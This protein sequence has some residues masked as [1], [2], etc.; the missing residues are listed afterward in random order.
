MKKFSTIIIILLMVLAL[1]ACEKKGN[2]SDQGTEVSIYYI[3]SKTSALVSE[4]YKMISTDRDEQIEELLYMLKLNPE[5][6]L[7]K[8]AFT[9]IV[10]VKEFTFNEDSSLTINFES[11]YHELSGINEVLC[12]AAVVKTIT[13]IPDVEFIQFAVNGQPLMDSNS[14]LVGIMTK[15]DFIDNTGTET[16][17]KLY[18]TNSKGNALVEYVTDITYTG[19]GSLEELV[20]KELMK[21][22]SQIGMYPTIP[23]GTEL[24]EVEMKEG[25]CYVDF[26]DK[27]KEKIPNLKDEIVIYSI[28]NTLIELPYISKVQFLING[29]V[30]PTFG[31]GI[32]FD[33]FFERNLSLI[34]ES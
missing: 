26:S 11:N 9:D 17:I 33:G 28:V 2:T 29:E 32:P 19:I 13:Q 15:E 34:D 5:N 12:R 18:F 14:N 7:Y 27:F 20:L 6:L 24:L 4:P 23:E 10:A 30:Q 25:V 8:S 16:K 21:G 1:A 3:D 31:D 22:P